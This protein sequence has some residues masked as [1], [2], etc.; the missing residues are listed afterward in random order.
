MSEARNTGLGETHF[1]GGI[2]LMRGGGGE[3]LWG[4]DPE[5]ASEMEDEDRQARI[6]RLE[7][8]LAA[9]K[10][11]RKKQKAGVQRTRPETPL[12]EL[13]G[14][15]GGRASNRRYPGEQP[16]RRDLEAWEAV[17]IINHLKEERPKFETETAFWKAMQQKYKPRTKHLETLM[18]KEE[19]FK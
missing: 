13:R 9:L 3:T 8:E 18:G 16:K 7:D 1:P 14:I 10:Q 15:A 12:E 6:K 4:E 2:Q 17:K 19:V 5:D 11:P